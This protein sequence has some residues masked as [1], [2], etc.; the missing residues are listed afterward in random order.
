MNMMRIWLIVRL[1]RRLIYV[2]GHFW[3]DQE[4]ANSRKNK[5][6]ALLILYFLRFPISSKRTK[7]IELPTA[8]SKSYFKLSFHIFCRCGLFIFIHL[9][10]LVSISIGLFRNS[11]KGKTLIFSLF[12]SN[13]WASSKTPQLQKAKTKFQFVC[14]QLLSLR[15]SGKTDSTTG[16]WVQHG[17]TS[18]RNQQAKQAQVFST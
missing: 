18:K 6:T 17:P 5:A 13:C 10:T 11:T 3:S 15:N 2:S 14:F 7:Q 9:F 16:L 1:R 4:E 12:V 8:V